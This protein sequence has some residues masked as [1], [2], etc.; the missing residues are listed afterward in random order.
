MKKMKS[1]N[2]EDWEKEISTFYKAD[3]HNLVIILLDSYLEGYGFYKKLKV[4]CLEKKGIPTQFI[5]TKSV[6]SKN[7]MSIVSNILL[8]VNSKIGGNSYSITIPA[9]LSKQNLMIIGVD[10]S[11]VN[12]EYTVAMCATVNSDF[13]E[14]SS[15][16][17]KPADNYSLTLP[18][19]NFV[20]EAITQYFKINKKLPGGVVIYRQGVSREQRN[21]LIP[22]INEV[23]NLMNGNSEEWTILKDNPIPY[24]YILVNKKSSMKFF[25]QE[26]NKS[27]VNFENPDP[28]L[29]ICN[30][31]VDSEYFEFYIQPQ[32]VRM[33]SASPTNF[34]VASGTMNCPELIT[35][36]TYDLCYLY[37]NWRGPVRVPAPLKYAEKLAK[38]SANLNEKL[39]NYKSFI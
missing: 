16:K 24:Y 6:S 9:E 11:T 17:L 25:E 23:E 2:I 27:S 34:T 29:L 39:K 14:Y 22:E 3:K 10:S 33:G 18:I 28:G 32:K 20:Y 12:G 5:L 13:T 37:C 38:I 1:E 21:Y 26:A 4:F 8:Q 35:K 19:A 7:S 31:I 15:K 36:L 30:G